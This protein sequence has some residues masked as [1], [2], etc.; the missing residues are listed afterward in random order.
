MG[1]LNA[2]AIVAVVVVWVVQIVIVVDA[3]VT[4]RRV[5]H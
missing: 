4:Y 1:E 5:V 3:I 2:P